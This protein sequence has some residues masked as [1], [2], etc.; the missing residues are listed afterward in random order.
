MIVSG[1]GGAR[2]I[3]ERSRERERENAELEKASVTPPCSESPRRRPATVQRCGQL[4]ERH[5]AVTNGDH[6]RSSQ[7]I[8]TADHGLGETVD[9]LLFCRGASCFRWDRRRI[10]AHSC[11]SMIGFPDAATGANSASRCGR[12]HEVR[13]PD[14]ILTLRSQT[15]A[16]AV[17]RLQAAAF[18]LLR[19]HLQ[20]H[21]APDVLHSLVIG[22]PA[23]GAQP[24]GDPRRAVT[25]IDRRQ[26][27]F[28]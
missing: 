11:C 2:R 4:T 17:I 19:R 24:D 13:H 5:W 23:F 22:E 7:R 21:L 14:V 1:D 27:G 25:T 28:L 12:R 8:P 3:V 6:S 15:N 20:A 18:A 10:A 26:F 16:G 9:S